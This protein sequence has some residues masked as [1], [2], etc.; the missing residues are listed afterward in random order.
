LLS[1]VGSIVISVATHRWRERDVRGARQANE[2]C[3]EV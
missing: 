3:C 1:C 2:W